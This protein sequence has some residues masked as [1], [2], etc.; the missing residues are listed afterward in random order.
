VAE[1]FA[2]VGGFR[3]GLEGAS[4]AYQ[5]VWS[6]QY[7]PSTRRQ[8]A[9]LIYRTRFGDQGHSDTDIAMV[10]TRDIPDHDLLCG[11]FPCQDYSVA[12]TRDH[13][14]GIEGKKG[15]LWWQIHRILKE[16]GERR[17]ACVLFENVDRLLASPARRR[18]RDFA[19]ILAS[20]A[21]LGYTVE[22]RVINSAD[23]GLPQRRRRTWILGYRT[24]SALG[25]R[26]ASPDGWVIEEGVMASA[27]PFLP[28][29]RNAWSFPVEGT[30]EEIS[31]RFNGENSPTPF[32]TAGMIAG[33]RVY[34]VEASP[35]Y[36]GERA[37]LGQ[38]LLKEEDVPEAFLIPKGQ[39]ERWRYVKGAKRI[40]RRSGDGHPYTYSE[41]AIPFPD[42]PQRP[43]RTI[44][45]KE[46][47]TT[48]SRGKH[49]VPCPSGRYRRLTPVELERLNGFPDNHTRH[50]EVF[51]VRRAFLMG[52]ALTVGVVRRIAETLRRR[53]DGHDIQI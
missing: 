49:V 32:R 24:D 51:D 52:N 26:I 31:A 20:L 53:W 2:G 3:L 12:A 9:S 45:T 25:R 13:A 35:V 8:D 44:T 6:N 39:L 28:D 19:I 48:P 10:P 7:E 16:K 43:S 14:K 21:D 4:P 38:I 33:R 40:E 11:G 36:L 27:F 23:Y 5:V 29:L 42:D 41:G 30:L 47:G 37:T 18:G 15:V 17:P 50:P 46:G 34:T 1:L 22:W